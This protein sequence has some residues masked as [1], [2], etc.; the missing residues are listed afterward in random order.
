MGICSSSKNSDNKRT[1][2]NQNN[3]QIDHQKVIED[4]NNMMDKYEKQFGMDM[5]I[6]G[7]INENQNI[8]EEG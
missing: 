1:E 2:R 3:N 7:E 4:A 5:G 8:N 6:E